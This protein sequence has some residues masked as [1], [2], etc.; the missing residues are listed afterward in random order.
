MI[1]GGGALDRWL[2]GR[3]DRTPGVV[4]AGIESDRDRMA[5]IMASADVFLHGSSAETF[6]LAIAEALCSGLPIV[7]P[8]RGGAVALL[9]P[10]VSE[11]YEPGSAAGCAAA[12]SRMIERGPRTL[13]DA[14]HAAAVSVPSIEE[15]FRELFALYERCAS[16]APARRRERL[17]DLAPRSVTQ[18]LQ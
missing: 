14:C 7:A 4:L 2:R 3:V 13:R 5:T 9:E 1:F 17:A 16:V 12:L 6:G 18:M 15:H 8:N 10:G 11:T